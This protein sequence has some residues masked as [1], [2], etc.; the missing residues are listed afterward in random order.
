MN[1][2]IQEFKLN[3]TCEVVEL[4]PKKIPI[5]RK[6]VYILKYKANGPVER[7]KALWR[8]GII[9]KLVLLT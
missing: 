1:Q 8:K 2:E 4:P 9:S 3:D 7:F 6:W 5:R